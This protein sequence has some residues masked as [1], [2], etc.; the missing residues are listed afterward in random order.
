MILILLI[1]NLSSCGYDGM[2]GSGLKSAQRKRLCSA[3]KLPCIDRRLIMKKR[4]RKAH[5]HTT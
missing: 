4:K 1:E 5:D 3:N 2:T